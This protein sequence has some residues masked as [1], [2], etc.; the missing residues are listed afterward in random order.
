MKAISKVIFTN[1]LPKNFTTFSKF[2]ISNKLFNFSIPKLLTINKTQKNYFSECDKSGCGCHGSAPEDELEKTLK[3][4][5]QRVMQCINLGN[6]SDAL[7]LSDEYISKVKT[8]FGKFSFLKFLK[9]MNI[10]FTALPL[11]IKHLS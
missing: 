11:T 3:S 7:E 6:F 8:N 5:N 4:L 1:F 2:Y 10:H 9:A